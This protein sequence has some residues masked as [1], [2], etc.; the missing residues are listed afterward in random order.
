MPWEQA[1]LLLDTG[2]RLTV[3][4]DERSSLVYARITTSEG[5]EPGGPPRLVWQGHMLTLGRVLA[6]A[7]A[8]LRLG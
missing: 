7:L 8:F 1:W 6:D 3:W 5:V 4:Q 2:Q